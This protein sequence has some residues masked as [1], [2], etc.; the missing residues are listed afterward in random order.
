MKGPI[1]WLIR[2]YQRISACTPAVCRFRPTCSQYAYSAI[3]R[4]GLLKGGWLALV[5]LS[6]CPPFHRG[7]YDPLPKN[8]VFFPKQPPLPPLEE[9]DGECPEKPSDPPE[10]NYPE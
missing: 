6:K 1:L 7:G 3:S 8:F 10:T 4:F 9:D 5:R 2:C